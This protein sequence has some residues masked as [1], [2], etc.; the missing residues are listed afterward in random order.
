MRNLC[1][2]CEKVMRQQDCRRY[3]ELTEEQRQKIAELSAQA[4]SNCDEHHEDILR[5]KRFAEAVA[6]AVIKRMRNAA[7]AD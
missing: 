7:D 5:Q 4:R 2:W 1:K 6:E 3:L